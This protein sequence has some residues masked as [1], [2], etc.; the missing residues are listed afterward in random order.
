MEVDGIPWHVRNLRRRGSDRRIQQ[1]SEDESPL[2]V[3]T[4]TSRASTDDGVAVAD[5]SVP[6]EDA[7]A[8]AMPGP[9]AELRRSERDRKAP[10]R[11]GYV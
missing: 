11:W 9:S 8:E 2:L 5:V 10:D 1:E 3:S 6:V 7:S 4:G